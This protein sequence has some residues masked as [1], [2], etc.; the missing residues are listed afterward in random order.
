M[1]DHAGHRA[2]L[3]ERAQRGGVAGERGQ[4]GEGDDI[5]TGAIVF[6]RHHAAVAALHVADGIADG[7][8]RVSMA[9]VITGSSSAAPDRANALPTPRWNA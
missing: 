3:G 1:E 5:G 7:V 2:A 8:G 4:R 6:D 9:T